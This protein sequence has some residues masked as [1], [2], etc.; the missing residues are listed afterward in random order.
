MRMCKQNGH[1][2]MICRDDVSA[3][4]YEQKS[5][6]IWGGFFYVLQH[7]LL[8]AD[9]PDERLHGY[10]SALKSI[11]TTN[12]DSAWQT[13][14]AHTLHTLQFGLTPLTRKAFTTVLPRRITERLRRINEPRRRKIELPLR[15]IIQ[16]SCGILDPPRRIIERLYSLTEA[17]EGKLKYFQGRHEPVPPH[18]NIEPVYG[19]NKDLGGN[20]NAKN[21]K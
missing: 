3:E 8:A 12:F 1:F 13:T 6:V 19:I 18:V 7:L 2:L 10:I 17:V 4:V 21:F 15:R 16:P 9:R 14:L 5:S 11:F 20:Q